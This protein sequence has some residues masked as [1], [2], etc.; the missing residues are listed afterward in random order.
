[1]EKN[2]NDNYDATFDELKGK[3]LTS[4]EGGVGSD[5]MIFTCKTG[6][7]YQLHYYEDCCAHCSVEEIHGDIEDIVGSKILLAEVVDN[8]GVP[9]EIQTARDK[10]KAEDEFYYGPDSETWVFYKLATIKGS[11]TIR[12][13]GTSNGYYSE[14]ATFER[15]E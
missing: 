2:Y 6:E 15:L 4:I 3:T 5:T 13:Y 8:V 9:E 12:W 1:M 10:Q 11:V 14:T 7:K